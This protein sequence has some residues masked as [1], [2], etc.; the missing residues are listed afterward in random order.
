MM[1][2][3]YIGEVITAQVEHGEKFTMQLK[4]TITIQNSEW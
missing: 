4:F 1:T 3:S 2:A